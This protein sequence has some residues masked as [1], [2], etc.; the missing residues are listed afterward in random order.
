MQTFDYQTFIAR[1]YPEI[2]DFHIFLENIGTRIIR[3]DRIWLAGGAIRRL[4]TKQKLDSDF[5]FFF[6][7]E[8]DFNEALAILGS[9]GPIE[10]RKNR[11][12]TS[13]LIRVGRKE[14]Q[15]QLINFAYFPTLE[16]VLDSFDFSICQCGFDGEKIVVGDNTLIDLANKRLIPHKITYPVASMRRTFK[17]VNQGYYM[18]GGGIADFLNKVVENSGAIQSD[19]EYLD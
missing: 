17:Y 15:I 12:N 11:H 16:A 3:K 5:D 6:R 8:D 13:L 14:F 2:S 4:L 19:F 18:C 10:E 1:Y 7:S 9:L